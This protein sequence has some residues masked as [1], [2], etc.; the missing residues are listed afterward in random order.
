MIKQITSLIFIFVLAGCGNETATRTT[1]NP[2]VAAGNSG[3]IQF[4]LPNDFSGVIKIAENQNGIDVNQT[5]GVYEITVPENGNVSIKTATFFKTWHNE[6][7]VYRNG[8][9]LLNGNVEDVP[10]STVCFFALWTNANGI[11]YY[12]VGTKAQADQLQKSAWQ[13]DDIL[14]VQEQKNEPTSQP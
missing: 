1:D 5:N 4:I 7:A 12:F 9:A 10:A 2:G 6:N 3:S 13:A 8:S 14:K 11:I